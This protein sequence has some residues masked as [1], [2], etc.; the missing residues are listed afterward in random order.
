MG[1]AMP[2]EGRVVLQARV[3]NDKRV[4]PAEHVLTLEQFRALI[5]FA[6]RTPISDELLPR[7]VGDSQGFTPAQM[8]CLRQFLKDARGQVKFL[9]FDTRR[10]ISPAEAYAMRPVEG[11]APRGVKEPEDVTLIMNGFTGELR[12]YVDGVNP[13]GGDALISVEYMPHD[14]TMTV[15]SESGESRFFQRIQKL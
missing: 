12:V 1:T 3:S 4:P 7:L 10:V 14:G 9:D 11:P 5:T 2:T 8:N 6:G 13:F 15:V